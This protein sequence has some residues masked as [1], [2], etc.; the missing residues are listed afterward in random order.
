MTFDDL[1]PTT[2]MVDI[3]PTSAI[4]LFVPAERLAAL[5]N[6]SGV[7][8]E[9]EYSNGKYSDKHIEDVAT[10]F[11]PMRFTS[12]GALKAKIIADKLSK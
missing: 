11:P 9:R 10:N 12:A 2:L 7:L 8:F 1:A 3:S 4:K 5:V 6:E